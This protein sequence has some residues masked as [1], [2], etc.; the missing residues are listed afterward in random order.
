MQK[1]KAPTLKLYCKALG[2]SF[3]QRRQ[4]SRYYVTIGNN[5]RETNFDWVATYRFIVEL[6][7]PAAR[8]T[9]GSVYGATFMIGDVIESLKN[10][11]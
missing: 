9:S 1:S 10:T 7:Y 2:Y 5:G 3:R 11:S 4:G 6:Y 8:M